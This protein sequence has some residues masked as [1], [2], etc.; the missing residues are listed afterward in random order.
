MPYLLLTVSL[1]QSP[2]QLIDFLHFIINNSHRNIDG[3]IIGPGHYVLAFEILTFA[4]TTAVEIQDDDGYYHFAPAEPE[5]Y[6]IDAWAPLLTKALA[7]MPNL[8]S[9]VVEADIDDIC[10]HSP[11]FA[12]T[13]LACPRL[14][15]MNLLGIGTPASNS[16]GQAI[17]SKQ[18]VMRL[19]KVQ[20]HIGD[21]IKKFELLKTE[22]FG[23]VLFSSKEHLEDL[24]LESACMHS[25][26]VDE[27]TS[28]AGSVVIRTPVVFPRLVSITLDDCDVYLDELANS[29]P[30]LRTVIFKFKPFL[31]NDEK[32]LYHKPS[33]PNLTSIQGHYQY[34]SKFLQHASCVNLLRLVID[35][36]WD[37][38]TGEDVPEFVVTQAVPC[39]KSLHITHREN[40]GVSWWKEFSQSLPALNYLFVSFQIEATRNPEG[41][42][43][44]VPSLLSSRAS[45]GVQAMVTEHAIA[46]SYAKRIKSLKYMDIHKAIDSIKAP[47]IWWKIIRPQNEY[48][49]NEDDVQLVAINE[50]EGMALRDW[51]D[52]DSLVR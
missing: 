24:S 7:L 32:S 37:P 39:L 11:D 42:C 22:G 36:L 29:F 15:D 47:R 31:I 35:L 9:V 49:N 50:V 40:S 27:R 30:G 23:S 44:H 19:R 52:M 6:P 10:L 16:F 1:N 48:S 14:T 4:C 20:H 12:A 17:Y 33:F 25:L 34:I 38:T 41:L 5:P 28:P 2:E 43:I 21:G 18:G 13:L 46:L 8:R 45:P 51:Y 26:L 3:E